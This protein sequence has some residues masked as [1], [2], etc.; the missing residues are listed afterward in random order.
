MDAAETIYAK[1]RAAW[2]AWLR[3]HHRKAQAIWLVYY[4]VNSGQPSVTY[5]EAVEEAICFG[6]IDGQVKSLDDERYMQRY[7]PRTAKSRWS[8]TNVARAEAMIER[9]RMSKWGL[10]VYQDGMTREIVP[11]T[12]DFTVPPELTAALAGNEAARRNYEAFP[13]SARLQ[14]VYWINDA[15]TEATRERR[16][17]KTIEALAANKRPGQR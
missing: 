10:Q 8:V 13:P 7:S 15:K 9:G 16:L 5:D 11:S 4:K 2:R 3:K 1:D 17:R 6:W 14:Y 12:G